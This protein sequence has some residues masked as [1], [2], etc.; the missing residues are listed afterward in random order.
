[1]TMSVRNQ[2]QIYDVKRHSNERHPLF[3]FVSFIGIYSPLTDIVIVHI[4]YTNESNPQTMPS[5]LRIISIHEYI[6]THILHSQLHTSIFRHERA[7]KLLFCSFEAG[8]HVWNKVLSL[9]NPHVHLLRRNPS[10][11]RSSYH[12]YTVGGGRV[13]A[14]TVTCVGAYNWTYL[15]LHL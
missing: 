15:V 10:C 12:G 2:P 6:N 4:V 3:Y 9:P 8:I 14:H 13:C 5:Y 11:R 7:C 1:M